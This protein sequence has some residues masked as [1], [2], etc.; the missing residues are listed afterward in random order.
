MKLVQN[1]IY[2][3]ANLENVWNIL[4]SPEETPKY[5]F[6]CKTISDWKP[7]SS[8]LWQGEHEGNSVVYV[9]GYVFRFEPPHLLEYSVI[10]PNAKYPIIPENHLM[11]KYELVQTE[12]Q[13]KLMV[14]QYGFETAA[15][16]ENRFVEISNNGIGWMP[17]LEEIKKIAENKGQ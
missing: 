12:N 6:G 15:D 2:I 1:E 11:V 3:N 5:M 17:I 4:T 16:G 7:G 14:S 9:S 10:D 8:L 13:I